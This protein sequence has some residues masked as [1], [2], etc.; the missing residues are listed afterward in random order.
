MGFVDTPSAREARARE[1]ASATG[2]VPTLRNTAIVFLAALAIA[3][4]GYESYRLLVRPERI[5]PIVIHPGGIDLAIFHSMISD[6]WS[7]IPV[8]SGPAAHVHTYPPAS[9]LLLAPLYGWPTQ[10]ATTV[11]YVVSFTLV[12]A[13]IVVRLTA[14]SG[15]AV[16]A[17]RALV[18]LALVAAYPVGAILGNGQVSLHALAAMLAALF[19]LRDHPVSWRRD[20]GVAALLALALAKPTIAAPFMLVALALPGGVRASAIAATFYVGITL[21]AATFQPGTAIEQ[22]GRFVA[23]GWVQSLRGGESNLHS[24]L[25]GAGLAAWMPHA[26]LAALAALAGFVAG[27]RRADPWLLIGVAAVAARFW[28]YHRWYDDL[29][30]LIAAIA[31]VRVAFDRSQP[32]RSLA[33]ALAIATVTLVLAPGG[34]YT[35]PPP[36]NSAYRALQVASWIADA[37]LLGLVARD[38]TRVAIRSTEVRDPVVPRRSGTA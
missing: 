36:W 11:V 23:L 30:I 12:L 24:L 6:W 17:E 16:R 14:E 31:L 19:A 3:W 1:R 4:L 28:T 10:A 33:A 22:L 27:C 8:Y 37:A 20:I 38:A 13:W 34:L 9:M 2:H 29:L 7:G 15:A 21:I 32:R 25:A 18:G 26:S 35:L 5:G